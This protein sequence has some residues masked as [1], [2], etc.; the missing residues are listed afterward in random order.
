MRIPTKTLFLLTSLLLLA[1]PEARAVVG[2]GTTL[3]FTERPPGPVNGLSV[4][5]VTFGFTIN[6]LASTDATF[7]ATLGPGSTPFN[8][9]PHL[10]GNT[11]GLLMLD[12]AS[13]IIFLQFG[14]HLS[15]ETD[16]TAALGVQLYDSS[17]TPLGGLLSLDMVRSPDYAGGLFQYDGPAARHAMIQFNDQAATRFTIDTLSFVPVPEPHPVWFVI[18]AMA[19]VIF[20]RRRRARRA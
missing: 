7:G 8:S 4:S 5:G 14:S 13:P 15:A 18:P 20:L 9:P 6:G 2:V 10:E 16:V 19:G 12:F 1:R 3:N 17:M 11:L